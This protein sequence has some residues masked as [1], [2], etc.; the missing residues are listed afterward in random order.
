[1]LDHCVSA[2]VYGVHLVVN[3]CAGEVRD[4]F[5]GSYRGL[6]VSYVEQEEALGTGDAVLSA[7]DQLGDDFLVINGDLFLGDG[8]VL[9]RLVD[10]EG[11]AMAVKEVP[12]PEHYGSVVVENGV[13]KRLV[14]KS[15]DPPSSLINAGVYRFS[16]EVFDL[17]EDV[18]LSERGEV[19]LTDAV[20]ALPEVGAVEVKGFWLDVGYPWDLLEANGK[21][22]N[23]LE[24]SVDGEVEDGATL[25]GPVSVGEGSVVKSGAYVEGPV[26]IG[27]GC[28]VGPNCYVRPGTSLGDGAKIGN[29][30]EVK[31]SV[32]LLGATAG[33]LSYV[34]D[35][36]LGEDCN[37]GAGT[38]FASL[39]HDGETV[40]VEV[41]GELV[42]SGRRKLGAVLGDGVKTGVNTSLDPGTVLGQ[43]LYTE[44]GEY[45][46]GTNL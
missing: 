11:A 2:G 21:A 43:G 27:E 8:E 40:G 9:E 37:L 1:L 34:G 13:V 32:L 22:L 16:P 25:K 42:D 30:V 10:G 6:E 19:E 20:E 24:P 26:L 5:G 45:V 39:R 41:K 38:V 36:V 46:S 33:H 17:L 35:S 31:N 4:R 18:G 29:G 28:E 12:D 7:R 15:P 23:G 14:E 44:P 3:Y